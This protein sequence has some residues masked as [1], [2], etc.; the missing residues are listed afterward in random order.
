MPASAH[1]AGH[2]RVPASWA[3]PSSSVAVPGAHS[4]HCPAP[5]SDQLPG[6]LQV[7]K[8]MR[9]REKRGHKMKEEVQQTLAAHSACQDDHAEPHP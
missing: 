9:M 4:V 8:G 7:C 5:G 6:G 3:V 1:H 2:E